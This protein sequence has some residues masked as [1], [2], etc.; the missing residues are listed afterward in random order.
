VKPTHRNPLLRHLLLA[1]TSLLG[2][3]SVSYSADLFWDANGDTSTAV[4]GI[5]NWSATAWRDGSTTGT[6]AAWVDGKRPVFGTTAAT[7]TLDQN[8][9]ASGISFG[10]QNSEIRGSGTHAITFSGGTI[11][12]ATG[13][14]DLTALLSGSVVFNP[15]AGTLSTATTFNVKANNSGLTAVELN[16]SGATPANANMIIDDAG[17]F[18][19]G[20]STVTLT[21]GILNI[22]ALTNEFI[23]FNTANGSGGGMNLNAWTTTLA[24]GSIR[25]R[26]GANTWNGPTT[27]T[28][29]SGLM[30]RGAS[31]V[32]LTFSTTA[33]IHLGS[34]TLTSS[35]DLSA[36][37]IR[38]Q[39]NITGTGKIATG[40]FT[41][42]GSINAGGSTILSGSNNYSGGTEVNFGSLVFLNA[43]SKPSLGNV[44]VAAASTLGLGVGASP[45]YFTTTEISALFAGTWPG[46]TLNATSNIGLD[47]TAADFTHAGT[48]TNSVTY[49]LAKLG[50]NKLTL[51][52]SNA[53]TGPTTVF[54]GS[55]ALSGAGTFGSGALTLTGGT[56]DLAGQAINIGALSVVRAATSGETITAGS[57]TTSG[58]AAN[59]YAVSNASGNA[60]IA[61]SLSA[62]GTAGLTKTGAGTVSLSGN[63]TY[64]GGT[65]VSAGG[66]TFLKTSALPA[67]GTV[68]AVATATIGLGVGASPANFTATEVNTLLAGTLTNVSGTNAYTVGI[69]TAAGDF[70]LTTD[71]GSSTRAIIKQG[72]NTLTLSGNNTYDKLISVGEGTLKAGGLTAFNNTGTLALLP[73]T[74]LDLNGHNAAFISMTS[75]TGTITTTAAGGGTD[76][77]TLSASNVDGIGN[78]FTDD[79]TRKLKLDFTSA[80]GAARLATTNI[81]NTYSGG[82]ILGNIMRAQVPAG[83]IGSPGAITSGAFGRGPVTIA[84]GPS[85]TNGAQI[86]FNAPDRILVNDVIVNGNAGNGNRAG[87]FRVFFPGSAVSGNIDANAVDAWFGA[88]GAAGTSLALTGKLTGLKGFRFFTSNGS[89]AWTATLNNATASPNDYAGNTI[90]DNSSVTLVLGAANQ[91]PNSIGKGHVAIN[92]GKLDLAGYDE[93]IN[94]L[95]GGAATSIDNLTAANSSNSLTLG[96]GDATASYAG[97]IKNTSG[98]LSLTKTGTGIQTLAGANDYDG[99]TLITSGTLLVN[100]NQSLA[101]GPVQVN[102][103]LGGTGTLGGAVTVASGGKIAPGT[104]GTI[105]TLDIAAD[106]S[107]AGTLACDVDGASTD[108]LAVTGNLTLT[109]STLAIN[110]IN[111]GTPGTYVIATYTGSRTGTLAGSLPAGYSVTYDD[112]NKEVELVIAAAGG[113]DA[114][115]TANNLTEGANGDDDKDGIINLVEYALGLNPQVGNPAPG[116]FVGNLL[117]FTKGTEAKTAGDLTY[118]I[119]TSTA[120]AA[121]SWTTAA[122]TQDADTISFQLPANQPGG[123]LFARLKVTRP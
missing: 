116:T 53:Y 98:T 35:S 109:G 105:E 93:T 50:A 106:T 30:T 54:G 76:T 83:T 92:F 94:G 122:A 101:T 91:I 73:G 77:L 9:A 34:F 70:D 10:I 74:T 117:T 123:K 37:G 82:L 43:A 96:D 11:T 13:G 80:T 103:T 121:G 67:S 46:V 85:N 71:L 32:A 65:T 87:S 14:Q 51:T 90:V 55:L 112:T 15:T 60:V 118:S 16:A 102:A 28:A 57:L 19:P 22:G 38:L 62:N 110:P 107:L 20:S 2:F 119:E 66:I 59:S 5:G 104:A 18:G 36:G 4:G 40:N 64:T 99:A 26:A 29:N 25:S 24:G 120:L 23:G 69:N 81:N 42:G 108:V 44:T 39:G 47:T 41:G 27:L 72:P 48:T 115:V 89:T 56:V 68:A 17:A 52:G 7:V 61:A 84:G 75:N 78:L 86:W 21:N 58:T 6:L 79:G 33:T 45:T 113:F 114:W 97:V 12:S 3:A 63:N 111:P 95:S 1:A 88:D 100:G 31:D 8:V 49:G